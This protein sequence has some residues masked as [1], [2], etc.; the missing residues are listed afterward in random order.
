M[1]RQWVTG[2]C[3]LGCE[4][5]DLPVIWLGPVQWDG[6]HAPLMSCEPCLNRL[7]VQAHAHFMQQRP[8]VA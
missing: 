8:A 4:R 2:D 6:Q 1:E 3:W 7:K 5:T